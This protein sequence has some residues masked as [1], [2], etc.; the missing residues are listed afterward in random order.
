MVKFQEK[1]ISGAMLMVFLRF[2]VK[3]IG[4]ISTIILTRLLVP[5]DFGLVAIAMSAYAFLELLNAFGFDAALIQK[6]NANNEHYDT[7]WTIKLIFGLF[8]SLLL[9]A[10]A[11]P[12]ASFF[13]DPRL[14]DIL[15]CI[16]VMFII[17][18]ITNIGVVDFRKKLN[19]K[20]DFIYEISIKLISS[21]FS[22]SLAVWLSNYWAL[23]LG[24]LLNSLIRVL[25]SYQLSTY[26]PSFCLTKWHELLQ[27]SSWLYINNALKFFNQ[28][29]QDIVIA[30]LSGTNF[31]GLYNIASEFANLPSNELVAAINRATYPGYAKCNISELRS[32]YLKV[33]SSISFLAIPACI[34]IAL[35]AP[36][37]VPVVLGDKWLPAIP[38]MQ[39]LSFAGVFITINQNVGYIFIAI[40]KPSYTTMTL[41]LR[42][43]VLL[44]LMFWMVSVHGYIGAAIAILITSALMFPILMIFVCYVL[45]IPIFLYLSKLSRPLISSTVMYLLSVY[46]FYGNITID[47]SI[48]THSIYSIY[49]LIKIVITGASIFSLTTI[50][51]WLIQGRPGGP[52]KFLITNIINSISSLKR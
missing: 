30:K 13:N 39:L 21:V 34:G 22:I 5:E 15:Y 49:S 20:R 26:R 44:I 25:L 12:I 35:I 17:D 27:F 41:A 46:L 24:M 52:E 8:S 38:I 31:V 48:Q 10:T 18:G 16:S 4:F 50:A 33:I 29:S 9:I 23:V 28:K 2:S 14:V 1:L 11:K 43:S 42:V 40:G 51:L 3:L 19:F 32:L 36:V 47:L 37:F 7:S 45:E 6:Q